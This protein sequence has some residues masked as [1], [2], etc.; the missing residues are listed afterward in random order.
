MQLPKAP[1]TELLIE[2]NH[3]DPDNFRNWIFRKEMLFGDR[4]KWW[5][6]F[7]Q[8]DFPH[9]GIDLCLYA[10]RSGRICHLDDQTRI[11]VMHDGVVRAVFKDYL[12][13]AVIFEHSSEQDRHARFLSAYAHTAPLKGIHPGA[14]VKSGDI[15]A[16][17]ADTSTSKAKI[18][19]HLHLSF[20]MPT[21]KLVYEGFV[22]NVMRDPDL[23]T[24]CDPLKII[25]WPHKE[26]QVDIAD[27]VA[28]LTAKRHEHS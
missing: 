12:G 23:L 6:D 11:P 4:G 24:L 7:G 1:F 13:Q 9:E 8:R 17:I 26:I 2:A 19:P 18:L 14:A 16:T 3:I 15:I 22:W 10:D 5:G 20:G 27:K 28:L 25:D 21:P